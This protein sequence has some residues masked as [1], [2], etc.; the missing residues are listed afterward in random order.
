MISSIS[1]SFG[2]SRRCRL[3]YILCEYFLVLCVASHRIV[4]SSYLTWNVQDSVQPPTIIAF[5]LPHLPSTVS[6]V[7]MNTLK[8][9]QMGSL[10]LDDLSGLVV[11]LG[12]IVL[13]SGWLT[14]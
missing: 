13:F 2:L 10:F 6:S 4:L 3:C 9:L 12:F 14:A 11:G 1:L 7:I 5:A 8:Y